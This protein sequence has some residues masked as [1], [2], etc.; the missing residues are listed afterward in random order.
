M[1]L[2]ASLTLRAL[3]GNS[4]FAGRTVGVFISRTVAASEM[5]FFLALPLLV[6]GAGVLADLR[7]ESRALSLGVMATGIAMVLFTTAAAGLRD[8]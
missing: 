4:H 7:A 8:S 2:F 1:V 5:V 3:K 6:L